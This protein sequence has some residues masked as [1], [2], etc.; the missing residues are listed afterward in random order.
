MSPVPQSEQE[1]EFVHYAHETWHSLIKRHTLTQCLVNEKASR[2]SLTY[3]ELYQ[4]SYD[5]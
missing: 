5:Q 2:T 4:A 1:V 3:A